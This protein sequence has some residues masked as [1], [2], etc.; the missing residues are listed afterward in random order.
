MSQSQRIHR[1]QHRVDQQ[2]LMRANPKIPFQAE[3]S[4]PLERETKFHHQNP[5]SSPNMA[6]AQ[7]IQVIDTAFLVGKRRPLTDFPF[8]KRWIIRAIYFALGWSDGDAVEVQSICTSRELAADMANKPGWFF[9]RLPINTPL[10]DEPCQF[11]EQEF[12]NSD[13]ARR[14]ERTHPEPLRAVMPE[15]LKHLEELDERLRNLVK[16]A[17]AG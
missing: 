2:H 4:L 17:R 14:Y 3:L 15:D 10:P 1:A 13:I 6:H 8:W 12:P 7:E 16:S 11:R 9:V 5:R